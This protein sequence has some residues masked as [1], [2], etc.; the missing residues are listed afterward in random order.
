MI[1]LAILGY[2][3]ILYLE[4]PQLLKDRQ[5]REILIFAGLFIIGT[6]MTL[7]RLYQWPIPNPFP[8]IYQI[9]GK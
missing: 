2:I 4:L 5:Y 3:L 6:Y 1:L 9:I 7:A 8:G